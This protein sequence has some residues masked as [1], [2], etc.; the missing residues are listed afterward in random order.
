MPFTLNGYN[1]PASTSPY[2]ASAYNQ[3]FFNTSNMTAGHHKLVVTYLGNSQ[4]TPL[5]LDYLIVQNGTTTNSSTAG[6]NSTTAGTHP[7]STGAP[8]AGGTTNNIGPIVGSVVGGVLLIALAIFAFYIRRRNK[9]SNGEQVSQLRDIIEPFHCM[10]VST[11]LVSLAIPSASVV[12]YPQIQSGDPSGRPGHAP[13]GSMPSLSHTAINASTPGVI[14]SAAQY[15]PYNSAGV[16]V[17]SGAAATAADAQP[18]PRA[19][20]PLASPPLSDDSGSRVVL[21][22]DSGIRLPENEPPVM[23]IPPVYTP[24]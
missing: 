3:N 20:Y 18:Q 21:H 2:E 10:P 24:R 12:T 9:R 19:Q 4:N 13:H 11:P 7:T 8:S 16:K 15:V 5:I 17:S 1:L 23:E 14:S 6:T 22:E